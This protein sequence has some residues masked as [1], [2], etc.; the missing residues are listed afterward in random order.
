[1]EAIDRN[2]RELN[3]VYGRL[4]AALRQDA[5]V[6]ASDPEPPSVARLRVSQRKWVDWR[7]VACR[8]V[9]SGP[10]YARARSQCFADQSAQRMQELRRMLA[11]VPPAL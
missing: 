8:G 3:G 11:D 4:I 6:A 2:D 9:G 7:D 10:L 1:M 5:E